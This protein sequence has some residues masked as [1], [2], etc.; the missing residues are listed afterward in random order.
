MTPSM[1]WLQERL[2]QEEGIGEKVEQLLHLYK[3]GQMTRKEFIDGLQKELDECDA[4]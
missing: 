1:D 4:S 2:S 3:R